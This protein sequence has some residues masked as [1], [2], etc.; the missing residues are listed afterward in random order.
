MSSEGDIFLSVIIPAY[1]EENRI[2]PSLERI[3]DYLSAQEYAA[4]IIV[5]DDGS[6]DE[7]AQRIERFRDQHRGMAHCPEITVTGDGINRGKG[8][9]VK[10]GM[11]KGCGRFLL[12][13]DA[14]LSTPIEDVEKL[15]ACLEGDCDIAFG[16]RS[17]PGSQVEVHQPL[18]REWMGKTFNKFVR[19]LTV[20]GFVDTQC[21]FKLFR[22]DAARDLFARQR[23]D[24]FSFDVEIL[25]LARKGGYRIREVPVRWINSPDTRVHAL[26]HSVQMFRDL[27]RIRALHRKGNDERFKKD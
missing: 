2:V 25:Y 9:A 23:L 24:G 5:V 6:T 1:N 22:R 21:G 14:D 7:T 18:Y 3:V 13:S 4:E 20:Q 26:H 17:L 19:L 11:L 15:L 27:F 12:F 16:S 8:A 10:R